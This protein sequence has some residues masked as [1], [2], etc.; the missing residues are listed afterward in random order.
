MNKPSNI[1]E[2]TFKEY[3]DAIL[4]GDLPRCRQIVQEL[5]D[6][7]IE[8]IDLY[9]NLF[10]RA[11]Y[12]IGEKWE[13]N[14]ISVAKEHLA[15]TITESLMTLVYP[16]IFCGERSGQKVVVSSGPN[17]YHQIGGKMVADIFETHGW[18]SYFL[19]ANTREGHLLKELRRRQPDLL[20]F[21][22]ALPESMPRL[23]Q[24]LRAVR[25][26]F[27]ILPVLVGG[28]A[29][30]EGAGTELAAD[31]HLTFLTTLEELELF[32]TDPT[33]A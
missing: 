7:D 3:L 13:K 22:A 28:R 8:V 2:D 26:E 25:A 11:Q 1:G 32:L 33:P 10:H 18:D 5:L 9:K 23:Q 30:A 4:A 20:V 6:A 27:P 24:S 17:E 14:L 12:E 31:P 29:I 15:T 16:K 21:S 19:G